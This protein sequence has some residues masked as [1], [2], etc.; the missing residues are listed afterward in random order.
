MSIGT[1]S[2]CSAEGAVERHHPT[3]RC[4][5]R[6]FDP[7]FTIALCLHCHE[8]AHAWLRCRGLGRRQV[9]LNVF[10]SVELR[11]RRL[12]VACEHLG[13]GR[14]PALLPAGLGHVLA[15]CADSLR[16]GVDALDSCYPQWRTLPALRSTERE[17]AE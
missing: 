11:L 9:D 16:Q 1:C 3:G 15:R 13:T 4:D 5:G 14:R 17:A 7:G 6:Y 12:G 2:R 8:A 10:E